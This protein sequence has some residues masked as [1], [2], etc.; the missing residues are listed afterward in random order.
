[1]Q[2]SAPLEPAADSPQ[3]PPQKRDVQHVYVEEGGKLSEIV[4]R[5]TGVLPSAVLELLRFGAIWY[6]PVPPLP[7]PRVM[8]FVKQEHLEQITSARKRA[9]AAGCPKVRFRV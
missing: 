9:Q 1:M 4:A 3:P 8:P 6:S 2:T 5:A 7:H